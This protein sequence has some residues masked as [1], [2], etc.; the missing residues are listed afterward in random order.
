M[1]DDLFDGKKKTCV[2]TECPKKSIVYWTPQLQ[3]WA[4]GYPKDETSPLQ[5]KIGIYFCD[6]CKQSVEG[7]ATFMADFF[8]VES[9]AQLEYSV[10]A[11]GFPEPDL[12]TVEI[13]WERK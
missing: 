11:A 1:S 13:K 7:Q 10:M 12:K 8:P 2:L 9:H 5:M 6:D 4:K 3:I